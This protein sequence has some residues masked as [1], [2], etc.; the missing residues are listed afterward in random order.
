MNTLIIGGS[1]GLG[2]AIAKQF[3]DGG[4]TVYV[5]GVNEPKVDFV[6][7]QMLDLSGPDM[8]KAVDDFIQALPKI[9]R[10]VYSAAGFYQV[11][12]V[13]EL[14]PEMI[15][16]MLRVTGT[17]LI[18]CVRSLLVKQGS[19]DELITIT[20]MSQWTPRKTEPIYNF[21]KAA[22]GQFSNSMVEDGRV[23]KVLVVAPS[24]MRFGKWDSKP[25]NPDDP[26]LD[27]SW[28]AEQVFKVEA[29]DFKYKVIKLLNKPPR[30]EEVDKR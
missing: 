9:D 12:T 8:P 29:G 4:A 1:S 3:A 5:T 2:L 19:L 24:A 22:T 26:L 6:K 7:F 13:T 17:A 14:E 10:L 27:K 15:E 20:S 11:A 28:V 21:A 30:V 18:Y 25:E 23:G 16:K